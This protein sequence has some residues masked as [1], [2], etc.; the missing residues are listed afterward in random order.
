MIHS[1][2]EFLTVTQ[3]ISIF[4]NIEVLHSFSFEAPLDTSGLHICTN[5]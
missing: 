2:L 3:I 1:V 5:E 4:N